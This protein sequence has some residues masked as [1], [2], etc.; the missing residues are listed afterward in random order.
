MS[1]LWPFTFKSFPYCN[2]L[3]FISPVHVLWGV[4]YCGYQRRPGWTDVSRPVTS[5]RWPPSGCRTSP[6]GYTPPGW[7]TGA[8]ANTHRRTW[9]ERK[10][11]ETVRERLS[12]HVYCML[13]N[14]LFVVCYNINVIDVFSVYLY[15]LGHQWKDGKGKDTMFKK[16]MK[17]Q[18]IHQAVVGTSLLATF[19]L[20]Y[21]TSTLPGAG[22]SWPCN[23]LP[24]TYE[25]RTKIE[26][27]FSLHM[28]ILPPNSMSHIFC[29]R[30]W[31]NSV[32]FYHTHTHAHIVHSSWLTN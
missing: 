31:R 11:K 28:R 16:R 8:P 13:K 1:V 21:L 17:S 26:F 10:T 5:A 30:D 15:V 9:R 20:L 7:G 25:T 32:V 12:W 2:T 24:F 6:R 23:I 19:D 4:F 22:L 27:I 14:I 18:E 29:C 3:S